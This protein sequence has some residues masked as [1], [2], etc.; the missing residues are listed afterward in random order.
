M[1]E[2]LILNPEKKRK[3]RPEF[4]TKMGDCSLQLCASCPIAAMCK[5]KADTMP[6]VSDGGGVGMGGSYREQL[7]DDKIRQV[8]GK[9]IAEP[10]KREKSEP[11]K[12]TQIPPK[13]TTPVKIEQ[14]APPIRKEIPKTPEKRRASKGESLAMGVAAVVASLFGLGKANN[15]KIKSKDVALVA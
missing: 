8:S 5:K 1:S 2:K 10:P 11:Q 13:P 6:V 12:P 14:K 15:P 9:I 4:S 3:S 7:L